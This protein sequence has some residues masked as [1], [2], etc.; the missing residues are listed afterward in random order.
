MDLAYSNVT[1]TY[2]TADQLIDSLE[3]ST[4][5]YEDADEGELIGRYQIVCEEC[6]QWSWVSEGASFCQRLSLNKTNSIWC[7]I[8]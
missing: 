6:S 5:N 3:G 2:F 4:R 1:Q 8:I 7:R